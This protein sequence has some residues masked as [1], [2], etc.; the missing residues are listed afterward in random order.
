MERS[1][2]IS[3]L[4][5][6]RALSKYISKRW[7]SNGIVLNAF[8]DTRIWF[9]FSSVALIA[10]LGV[11]DL[12][13]INHAYHSTLTKGASVQLVFGF[14][15]NKMIILYKLLTIHLINERILN[16][17]FEIDFPCITIS[18]HVHC[19]QYAI[20]MT[21]VAMTFMKYILHSIDL[22]NEN[23]WE[24]KAVYLLYTELFLGKIQPLVLNIWHCTVS[25]W[26]HQ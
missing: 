20:L 14:E 12:Y 24:N 25:V 17:E 10:L 5:H 15:V 2:V 7:V 9:W 6:I 16:D 26:N 1:P 22:Q 23:P 8:K 13:F 18:N 3:V 19:F 21:I 4:F 11:L